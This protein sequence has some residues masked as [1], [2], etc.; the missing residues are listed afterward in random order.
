MRAESE[1]IR[2]AF[3]G[4]LLEQVKCV[5][6][7]FLPGKYANGDEALLNF[8]FWPKVPVK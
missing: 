3:N 5:E 8:N 1:A 4:D 6:L 7:S 2:F